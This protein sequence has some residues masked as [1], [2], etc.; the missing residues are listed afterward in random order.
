[1]RRMAMMAALALA[2][3]GSGYGGTGRLHS[4]S[5]EKYPGQRSRFRVGTDAALTPESRP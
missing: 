4:P 3:G 5:P 1:M 2:A